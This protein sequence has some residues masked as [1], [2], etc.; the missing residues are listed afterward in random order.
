[1]EIIIY[2]FAAVGVYVTVGFILTFINLIILQSICAKNEKA[3]RVVNKTIRNGGE[4]VKYILD[5][6]REDPKYKRK[7]EREEELRWI[8]H[9]S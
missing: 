3:R 1:M 9:K 2:V 5:T 6:I 7:K 8:N 4:E